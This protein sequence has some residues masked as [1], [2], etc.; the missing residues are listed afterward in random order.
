LTWK[1]GILGWPGKQAF[2]VALES[3]H[4]GWAC[5]AGILGGSEKQAFWM[6]L[7]GI[8]VHFE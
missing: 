1:A 8:L 3:R 7:A 6:G 4:F 5:K 2:W